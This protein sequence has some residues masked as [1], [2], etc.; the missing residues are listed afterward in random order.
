MTSKADTEQV[1]INGTTYSVRELT[2]DESDSIDE[3]AKNPD[4]TYNGRLSTRLAIAA[5]TEPP[6]SVDEIGKLGQTK[7][8]ALIRAFNK[9]NTL[10][11]P[12]DPSQSGS[13]AQT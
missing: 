11:V 2:V 7:Y 3:A 8:T 10:P 13:P 9:M 4:G 1:K 6:I 12:N 5:A